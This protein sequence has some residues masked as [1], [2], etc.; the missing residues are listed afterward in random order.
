MHCLPAY[1]NAAAVSHAWP[2][3][4]CASWSQNHRWDKGM[5]KGYRAFQ[6]WF[7]W[8]LWVWKVHGWKVHG[9]KVHD[10][11]VHDWKVHGWKVH[12]W[13]IHGLKVYCWKVH[14]WKVHGWKADY[15]KNHIKKFIAKKFTFE[16]FKFISRCGSISISSTNSNWILA[17]CYQ[18]ISV[19]SISSIKVRSKC[20]FFWSVYLIQ[21]FW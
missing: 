6:P 20:K 7:F 3:L 5:L 16:K 15:W 1:C 17:N 18:I 9:W 8:L 2:S 14:G 12:G 21:R 19:E 4:A 11:K 10:W 13:K